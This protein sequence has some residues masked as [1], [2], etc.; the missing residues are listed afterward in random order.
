MRI[1]LCSVAFI[2]SLSTHI[3]LWGQTATPAPNSPAAQRILRNLGVSGNPTSATK[4][5]PGVTGQT[6]T[7]STAN[8][9]EQARLAKLKA[10]KFDRRRSAYIKAW[11]NIGK[12]EEPKKKVDKKKKEEK[13]PEV[14]PKKKPTEAE[15]KAAALK[16]KNADDLKK[17][18]KQIKQAQKDV[19]LGKWDQV[20]AFIKPL[21]KEEAKVA[22]AQL[23]ASLQTPPPTPGAQNAS[24]MEKS[25]IQVDDFMA[26][27]DMAPHHLEFSDLKKLSGLL[28]ISLQT[29]HSIE[30]YMVRFRVI[31]KKVLASYKIKDAKA[32]P[33]ISDQPLSNCKNS[34]DVESCNLDQRIYDG[35]RPCHQR[36]KSG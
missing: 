6:K 35:F 26:V 27:A 8:A 11:A 4:A 12:K 13:K 34:N 30:E 21:K 17:L 1:L 5:K 33:Q 31:S 19:T 2:I 32:R 10:M 24:Y 3:Q 9:H 15:K 36:K 7:A 29:G 20:K 18:D 25:V 16:K 28:R 14:K 22:Y 23:L